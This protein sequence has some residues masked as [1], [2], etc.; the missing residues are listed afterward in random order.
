MINGGEVT[1]NGGSRGAGIGGGGGFA[2]GAGGAGGAVTIN[3]GVVHA[4]GGTGIGGAGIGGGGGSSAAGGAAGNILIYGEDTL[5][6]A[7]KGSANAQDIGAGFGNVL[8]AAG[9]VFVALPKGSLQNASGDIG[10]DVLFTATPPSTSVVTATLPAPFD[11]ASPISLMTGLDPTGKTFSVLTTFGA[12]NTI[13]FELF[14]YDDKTA[15]GDELSSG[16]A[17]IHFAPAAVTLAG[18][19]VMSQPAQ[20]S[21]TE[22]Q[23]L[24]LSGLVVTL[25]YSDGSAQNVPFASFGANITTTPAHGVALT[26]AAHHNTVVTVEHTASGF[27]ATTNALTVNPAFVAVTNITGVPTTA[28][29]GT[30]LALSGT[31]VPNNATNQTIAWSVQNAGTTGATIVGNT[32]NTT[33]AGTVTVA[34]TI[35]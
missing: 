21:Y 19:A 8:G 2:M 13:V 3:G 28:T 12:G 9:N 25:N 23:N 35:E 6:T 31:V 7:T 24:D 34:A 27:T 20:L 5:V 30:P 18:I 4:R 26:V 10:Y 1:A 15:T 22:G 16:S 32:L 33:A 11:T 17:E 29:A 14:N